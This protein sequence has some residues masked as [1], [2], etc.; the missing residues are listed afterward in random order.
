MMYLLLLIFLLIIL[1]SKPMHS[2]NWKTDRNIPVLRSKFVPT[3]FRIVPSGLWCDQIVMQVRACSASSFIE[4]RKIVVRVWKWESDEYLSVTGS[5]IRNWDKVKTLL[6][7]PDVL[8]NLPKTDA[9]WKMPDPS[10]ET[11]LTS[12][13]LNGL[14]QKGCHILVKNRIF[15]DTFHNKLLVLVILVLVMIRTSGSGSFL[16]KLGF[17][18]CWGQWG[19]RGRWGQWGWRGF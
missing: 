15:D 4:L 10:I 7:W 2:K 16:G 3:N 11:F 17:R 6:A 19:Y 12:C 18:G 9:Q 13:G 8:T 5:T 14:R 1:Q